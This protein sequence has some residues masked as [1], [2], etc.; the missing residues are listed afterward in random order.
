VNQ[1]ASIELTA[2]HT[3]PMTMQL[4]ALFKVAAVELSDRFEVAQLVLQPAGTRV[5]ITL[6]PQSRAAGGS[7]FETVQVRLDASSR[8]VEFILNS[9]AL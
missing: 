3:A 9:A 2:R 7:E 5:R 1:N 8:I 4:L 6:D